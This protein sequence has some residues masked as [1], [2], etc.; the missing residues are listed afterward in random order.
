MINLISHQSFIRAS[1]FRGLSDANGP[2]NLTARFPVLVEQLFGALARHVSRDSFII[3][4]IFQHE[5]IQFYFFAL[6][7]FS[8]SNILSCTIIIN[9]VLANM[10]LVQS[11]MYVGQCIFILSSFVV[12]VLSTIFIVDQ[13]LFHD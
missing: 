9:V 2:L 13:I 10:H 7:G 12:N 5:Y 1:S 6:V 11:D 3:L 4:S 8:W